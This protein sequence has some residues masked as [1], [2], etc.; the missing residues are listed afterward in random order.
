MRSALRRI[1]A[2]VVAAAYLTGCAGNFGSPKAVAPETAASAVDGKGKIWLTTDHESYILEH[3]WVERDSVF[4][5]RPDGVSMGLALADVRTV[6]AW[7]GGGW[8]T[9][10]L[11]LGIYGGLAIVYAIA[12][13]SD[14]WC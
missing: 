9:A 1:V 7:H 2:T 11:V 12:C 8:K 10:G 4:G 6:R 13:A 5:M 3:T 14:P